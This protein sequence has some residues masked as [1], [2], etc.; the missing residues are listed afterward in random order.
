M[1]ATTLITVHCQAVDELCLLLGHELGTRKQDAETN[2][3]LR[4]DPHRHADA[5][6]YA[7]DSV[8]DMTKMRAT[9]ATAA[10]IISPGS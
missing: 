2:L 8:H 4:Y 3:M 5:D 1:I 10:M 7:S 9:M 6:H